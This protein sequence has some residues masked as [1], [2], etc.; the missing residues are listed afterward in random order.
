MATADQTGTRLRQARE[1]AGLSKR[2]LA[3]LAGVTR[4]Q[5][6]TWETGKYPPSPLSLAKLIPHI[7][8]TVDHYLLDDK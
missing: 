2:Q 4:W 7:G 8:G 1:A 5:I 6:T 3:L